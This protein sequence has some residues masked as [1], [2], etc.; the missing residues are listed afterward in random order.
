MTLPVCGLLISYFNWECV[1]YVTGVLGLLW[2]AA[3]YFLMFDSPGQHPRITKREREYLEASIG[4]S[5]K[6][7]KVSGVHSRLLSALT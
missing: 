1:F 5:S 3:W 2:T 4:A 6:Q 7:K